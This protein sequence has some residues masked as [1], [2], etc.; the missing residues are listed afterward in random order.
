MR[1][2]TGAGL[3]V[4]AG[5]AWSVQGVLIA[6]IETAQSWTVLFWRSLGMLPVLLLWIGPRQAGPAIRAMGWAG[7][8]GGAGLVFAFG[9]A[10]T[11]LQSTTVA[12]AVLLFSASPFIAALLGRLILREPVSLVTWGAICVALAGIVIMVGGIGQIG[13]LT[14]FGTAAALLSATGFAGFTVALRWGHVANTL[15]AVLL[16]GAFATLTGAFGATLSGQGL[17]ASAHDAL[18][19]MAM[20]AVTLVGGMLLYTAG[21]RVVPAAQATL[22]SL[23]EVLL[24]LVW[25][26]A[27]LGETLSTSTALGG[28]VLLAA[29][30]LNAAVGLGAPLSPRSREISPGG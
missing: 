16:G 2:L 13:G 26:W 19:S 28:A 11:A 1:Y 12:N 3:V 22:L 14:L 21:S 10:I 24:A 4:A 15:P 7:V 9:G 27:L 20:G 18:L 6:Q 8:I 17:D 5:V 25:A 30:T 23:V 29:V